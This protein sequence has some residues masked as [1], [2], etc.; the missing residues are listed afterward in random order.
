[1][2]TQ[3]IPRQV[4][5]KVEFGP[6]NFERGSEIYIPGLKGKLVITKWMLKSGRGI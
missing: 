3:K 2:V 4:G 1:M 5:V 6:Y